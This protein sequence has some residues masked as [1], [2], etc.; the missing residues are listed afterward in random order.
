MLCNMVNINCGHTRMHINI[1]TR[2]L[3]LMPSDLEMKRTLM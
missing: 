3:A 2:T 1:H